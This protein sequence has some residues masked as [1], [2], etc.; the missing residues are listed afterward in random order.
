[1][2]EEGFFEEE[3]DDA[4]GRGRDRAAMSDAH[5]SISN[6]EG[7]DPEDENEKQMQSIATA[8]HELTRDE[9]RRHYKG[10][11]KAYKV[12]FELPLF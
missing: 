7:S 8:L 1:M 4:D 5:S 3:D 12:S 11:M 6:V 9:T 2:E 10:G